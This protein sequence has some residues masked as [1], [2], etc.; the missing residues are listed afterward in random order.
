MGGFL[1]R[2]AG[3]ALIV[4]FLAS[5][6]VFAGVRA[7]PGDPGAR[8][9]RREPRPGGARAHPGQVRPGRAGA[10][11]VR[12]VGVARRS[13][14]TW[15]STRASCRSRD[16][17]VTRLPITLELAGLAILFGTLLG[18][19]AGVI[20]AVRR[21]KASDHAATMLALVGLSL[22]HFWLGLLLIILFAVNLG[23]A[24]GRRVRAVPRGPDREP[25]S[26]C[27]SR[28]SCSARASRPC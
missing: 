27:C 21:G 7:L 17:I 20:A 1:L 10:R 2:R 6:L 14:A 26:T 12:Q 25:A 16:T 11:P 23:L 18:V 15:A 13:R 28:H 24:A 4:I 5:I 22:P 19:L 8:A 3:A 9:R